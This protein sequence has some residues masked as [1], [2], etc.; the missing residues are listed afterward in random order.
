[1]A[2][3]GDPGVSQAREI[4]SVPVLGLTEAALATAFLLGGRFGI[5]G[6]SKRIG[7][8]YQEVIADLGMTRRFAGYSGLGQAF[9][10]VGTV[11]DEARDAL[12]QMCLNSVEQGAD[13]I[14]LAGAPLA[15]LAREIAPQVPVPLQ[16]ASISTRSADALMSASG[17]DSVE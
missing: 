11:H 1:M 7:Y 10:D 9:A 14:I 6:I 16:G 12:L 2:A 15:G 5:V 8:W 3:F 4:L 13:S 17:T